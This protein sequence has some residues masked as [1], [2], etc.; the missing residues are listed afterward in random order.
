MVGIPNGTETESICLHSVN[1]SQLGCY[2][3]ACTFW[4]EAICHRQ[5]S[6]YSEKSSGIPYSIDSVCVQGLT[7]LSECDLKTSHDFYKMHVKKELFSC[8][9]V[10]HQT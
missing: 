1:S 3:R 6:A 7:A 8:L 2:S 4:N 10:L 9:P 5:S